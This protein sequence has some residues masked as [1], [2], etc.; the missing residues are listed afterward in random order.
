MTNELKSKHNKISQFL[1]LGSRPGRNKVRIQSVNLKM[2]I[3]CAALTF[4]FPS[5]FM[6]DPVRERSHTTYRWDGLDTGTGGA[7]GKILS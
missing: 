5:L 4:C 2:K 1:L 7:S 6:T 3:L